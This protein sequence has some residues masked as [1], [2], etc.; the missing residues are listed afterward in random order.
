MIKKNTT[1]SEQNRTS[2]QN[3]KEN[4]S[5]STWPLPSLTRKTR[6]VY[7]A[8]REN[9]E[10]QKESVE[11]VSRTQRPGQLTA[12]DINRISKEAEEEGYKIGYEEG[13]SK[14][15]V[16][17]EQ[18]GL[19]SGEE[20]AYRET[21]EKLESQS[22]VL[23]S[24]A[25]RLFEP[26]SEQDD[27]L[28]DIILQLALHFS[29][30]ILQVEIENHPAKLKSLVS[31]VIK[32]VPAGSKNI[33]IFLNPRDAELLQELLQLKE[34][35]WPIEVDEM[36]SSGGCRVET[37]ESI[38]DYSVEKRWQ[39]FLEHVDTPLEANEITDNQIEDSGNDRGG[40]DPNETSS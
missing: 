38:V 13:Y 30:Q 24:I 6:V 25:E 3:R 7:S 21:K 11:K 27:V 29:Q 31:K 19:K 40:L 4:E 5:V 39:Y 8:T 34:Q 20:R 35:H 33:T 16:Q 10:K 15:E 18:K 14:G 28:E 22:K 32:A 36:L 2:D 37:R 23:Q 9:A 12:Q 26:M 1:N 17:G